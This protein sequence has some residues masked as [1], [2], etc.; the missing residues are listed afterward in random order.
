[1][2]DQINADVMDDARAYL[3]GIPV[4]EKPDDVQDTPP[5]TP[6]RYQWTTLPDR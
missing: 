6:I 5:D 2:T 1:M 4:S 3:N